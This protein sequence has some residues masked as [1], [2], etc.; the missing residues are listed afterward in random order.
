M[1]WTHLK[2]ILNSLE[3]VDVNFKIQTLQLTDLKNTAERDL[4]RVT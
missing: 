4:K 1:F 3:M 2:M